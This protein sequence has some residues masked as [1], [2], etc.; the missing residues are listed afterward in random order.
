[1]KRKVIVVKKISSEEIDF[2]LKQG[3]VIILK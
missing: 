3:Y 1:M 2:L